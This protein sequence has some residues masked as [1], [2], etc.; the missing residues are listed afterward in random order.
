MPL[1]LDLGETGAIALA[2]A[3]RADLVL[4]DEKRGHATAR[5]HGRGLAGVRGELLWAHHAG[6]LPNRRA[7]IHQLR[8]KAGFFVD[9]EIERFI[10]AQ[11]G[12]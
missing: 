7:G 4:M 9:A 12:E 1:P 3:T 10:H 6:L 5:R 2:L 8:S 11:I